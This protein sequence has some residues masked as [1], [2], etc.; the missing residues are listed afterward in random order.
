MEGCHIVKNPNG[1]FLSFNADAWR[2]TM[3][4]AFLAE[5]GSAGGFTLYRPRVPGE[6]R[7]Y[8]EHIVAEVLS[9]KYL[10]DGGWRWEWKHAPGVRNW[11]L[12]DTTT[13][14]WV[15]AASRGLTSG[16]G[17]GETKTEER[18][19]SGVTIIQM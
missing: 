15:A 14:C 16:G 4:R 10:T 5:P 19:A 17:A 9:N 1:D 3:Q 6:H 11:D 12:G 18:R 7:R 2:E 13:G 8:A